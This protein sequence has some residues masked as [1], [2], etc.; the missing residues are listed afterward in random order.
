MAKPF[1]LS[2][3][4]HNLVVDP[5]TITLKKVKELARAVTEVRTKHSLLTKY[6]MKEGEDM[7]VYEERVKNE[8]RE[9]NTRKSGETEADFTSRLLSTGTDSQTFLFDQIK[10]VAEVFGQKDKVEDDA[11][12]FCRYVAAKTFVEDVL[13]ICDLV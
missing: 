8:L 2:I 7:E 11:M 9:S 13:S 4:P 5:D 10:A 6:P 12:E 3:G 1:S